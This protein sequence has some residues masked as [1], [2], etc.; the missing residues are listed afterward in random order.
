MITAINCPCCDILIDVN[1]WIESFVK[2]KNGL[3][4]FKCKG[5]K[6]QLGSTLSYKGDLC[7]W[8]KKTEI[9]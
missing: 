4:Y 9:K 8:D 2:S 1:D 7:I 5:C 3:Y 6:T